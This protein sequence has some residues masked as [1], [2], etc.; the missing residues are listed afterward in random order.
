MKIFF[1]DFV[2]VELT[3]TDHTETE[4]VVSNWMLVAF[5]EMKTRFFLDIQALICLFIDT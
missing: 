2:P 5:P 4:E 1:E 3:G